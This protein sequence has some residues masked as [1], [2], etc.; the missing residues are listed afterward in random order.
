MYRD[1]SY[2]R[3][4]GEMYASGRYCLSIAERQNTTRTYWVTTQLNFDVW[5][6]CNNGPGNNVYITLDYWGWAAYGAAWYP[7]WGGN[8]GVRPMTGHCHCP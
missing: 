2:I 4:R 3:Q 8:G 6:Y 7:S 1:P 5:P